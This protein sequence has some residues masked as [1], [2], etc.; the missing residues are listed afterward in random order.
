MED[1]WRVE[2][3]V[4]SGPLDLLLY[5][6]RRD[7]LDVHDIPIARITTSYF[8]YLE[9]IRSLNHLGLDINVAGDF[10]VMA[11]TLM[12]I[13]SRELLP[14][15]SADEVA[16][17]EPS[18][19]DDLADPKAELIQQLLA[20]KRFKDASNRLERQR[21]VHTARFARVPAF[22]EEASDEPPPL[23]MDEVQVFDLLAAFER[24]MAE[25]GRRGPATH[26]VQYD[27][28]PLE[29]HAADIED[30][31]GREGPLRL[32]TLFAGGK[33]RGEMI[34]LFLATLELVRQKKV[35]VSLI[36]GSEDIE[37]TLAPPEH[38]ALHEESRDGGTRTESERT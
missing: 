38:R 34:G 2:L 22:R 21:D 13:K 31:L 7:E 23:D 36:E 32:G 11:A 25:V 17:K 24:L 30:R 16:G 9:K 26:D 18:A 29:L 10:L 28:T 5:L 12:E 14:E 35:L 6:I 20:Y 33:S 8:N 4:F 15:A 1:T 3:D 19:V 27:D 37:I